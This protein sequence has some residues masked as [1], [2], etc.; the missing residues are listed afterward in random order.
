MKTV[1]ASYS[2]S[3]VSAVIEIGRIF[4]EPADFGAILEKNVGEIVQQI[5]TDPNQLIDECESR[6]WDNQLEAA[7]VG[8]RAIKSIVG[9][10]WRYSVTPSEKYPGRWELHFQMKEAA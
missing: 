9:P 5:A 2:D 8:E 10:D 1:T 6:L 3:F 4:G 7:S